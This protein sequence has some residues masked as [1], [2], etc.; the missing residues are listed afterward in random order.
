MADRFELIAYE[1]VGATHPSLLEEQELIKL[2]LAQ[3]KELLWELE[4][5]TVEDYFD[6][7]TPVP[8]CL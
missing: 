1:M 6:E 5:Q 4:D 7:S 3:M 8:V 2:T